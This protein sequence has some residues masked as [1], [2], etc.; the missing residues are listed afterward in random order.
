MITNLPI[1]GVR[2]RGNDMFDEIATVDCD[3]E[4]YRWVKTRIFGHAAGV[5]NVLLDCDVE[6]VAPP[7]PLIEDCGGPRAVR[8]LA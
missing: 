3:Q 6:V 1:R 7:N 2:L 4:S 5:K 8:R